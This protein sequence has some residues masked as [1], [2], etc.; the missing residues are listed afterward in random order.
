MNKNIVQQYKKACSFFDN[1]IVVLFSVFL[2]ILSYHFG[3]ILGLCI[4]FFI[5]LFIWGTGKYIFNTKSENVLSE[6]NES[7][8][9]E[10]IIE[11]INNVKALYWLMSYFL[12]VLFL[13]CIF[14]YNSN[15][16]SE[17]I[18]QIIG[19][20]SA[21]TYI[22]LHI[23]DLNKD[24]ETIK[25]L[26][27][28]AKQPV[29]QKQKSFLNNYFNFLNILNIYFF[30][31]IV[32]IAFVSISGASMGFVKGVSAQDSITLYIIS[33]GLLLINFYTAGEYKG[34]LRLSGKA[35]SFLKTFLYVFIPTYI[36]GM[37][38]LAK[39]VIIISDYLISIFIGV[40]SL[41]VV[42]KD[43]IYRKVGLVAVGRSSKAFLNSYLKNLFRYGIV[44]GIFIVSYYGYLYL[45]GNTNNIQE[46]VEM[47][48]Y[49]DLP[50]EH[51]AFPAMSYLQ[52]SGVLLAEDNYI[53]PDKILSNEEVVSI[54]FSYFGVNLNNFENDKDIYFRY[55]PRNSE[56]Y[57]L[58]KAAYYLG[59]KNIYIIPTQESTKEFLINA[60][61]AFS[62]WPSL[63][64]NYIIYAYENGYIDSINSI[65]L[66]QPINRAVMAQILFNKKS[67]SKPVYKP[68]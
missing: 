21:T 36:I 1:Y 37:L 16:I 55:I 2:L 23:F 38:L 47:A 10:V 34:F 20:I 62:G 46:E 53:F 22:T 8:Y 56:N 14:L 12:L 27:D 35:G 33:L 52:K 40:G 32:L 64:E 51:W 45:D 25:K 65:D 26:E 28:W 58:F 9:D 3:G 41:W 59:L 30:P 7:M 66:K 43:L 42:Y 17:H 19:G 13:L 54:L 31:I 39:P 6:N 18:L 57:I 63:E 29:M 67:Q 48:S 4:L 61:G 68:L 15:I 44:I 11:R 50:S 60:L 5:F 24:S 49:E